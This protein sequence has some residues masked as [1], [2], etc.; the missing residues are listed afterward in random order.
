MRLHDLVTSEL[1]YEIDKSIFWTD[2]MIVL[3]YIRNQTKRF[4]TCVAN[5]VSAI[6]EQTTQDQWRHV[7]TQLN[8]ADLASRGV[9][10]TATSQLQLWVKGP[11]FLRQEELHW[12]SSQSNF[13]ID[14]QDTEVKRERNVNATVGESSSL[15]SLISRFSNWF[16]LRKAFAWLLRF[17]EYCLQ[18]FLKRNNHVPDGALTECEINQA[19]KVIIGYV[20]HREF[21]KEIHDLKHSG[22]VGKSSKLAKL[23][24]VLRDNMLRVGGRLKHRTTQFI[25]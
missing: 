12:P 13:E 21:H 17:R 14:P 20:Q 2:S 7:P 11:P 4:K 1:E 18:R 8:P 10:P 22:H 6:H 16:K 19:A 23:V 5:R 15:D 24:P 3:G 9:S 25:H